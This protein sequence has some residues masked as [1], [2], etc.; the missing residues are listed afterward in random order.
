MLYNYKCFIR[1]FK[2][3]RLL[4]N[5]YL[6]CF[7]ILPYIADFYAM[8]D[9]I[10][11][12]QSRATMLSLDALTLLSI[13][14]R[15]SQFAASSKYVCVCFSMRYC[16]LCACYCARSSTT[17][18]VRFKLSWQTFLCD[19][20]TSIKFSCCFKKPEPYTEPPLNSCFA[21]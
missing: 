10:K 18:P 15:S 12:Y 7:V 21:L 8:V 13:F 5:V 1:E 11:V 6:H 4:K 19:A 2:T 9:H 3:I 14:T 20:N 16:A 17:S